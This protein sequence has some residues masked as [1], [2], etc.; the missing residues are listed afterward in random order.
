MA[1]LRLY[2][3]E[4]TP[5]HE[6]TSALGDPAVPEINRHPRQP[7]LLLGWETSGAARP[8]KIMGFEKPVTIP[9]KPKPRRRVVYRGDGHLLCV[10]PTGAGKGRGLIIPNLLHYPGPV[11]VS[12]PKGENFLV[13][14]LCRREMGH[15]VVALDP[16]RVAT[17]K[18]DWLNPFDVLKLPSSLPDADVE[19]LAELITGGELTCA[20]DPFWDLTGGGLLIGLLGLVALDDDPD[21]RNLAT[22]LDL[23]YDGDCDYKIA[24]ELDNKR[25]P[26][27]MIYNELAG[28]LSHESD[29]CRPSVRSTAQAKVKALGCEAVREAMSG[30][31]F[32]LNA[33]VR[34][35]PIDIFVILPPD[36][37]HSHRAVLRLWLGVIMTA[38]VRRT[39]IPARRT[40]VLLDE[41]AQLGPLNILRQAITLMR[42][43]GVQ[44]WTFWQDLSQLKLL[45]PQDWTTIVNNAAVI[46]AF[47]VSNGLMAAE[48][49]A[50][51]GCKPEELQ[52]LSPHRQFAMQ[53]RRGAQAIGRLD[54]L[55]DSFFRGRFLNNPRHA[56]HALGF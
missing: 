47:G 13:T 4:R 37:L 26:Q 17:D 18:G 2:H 38:L 24:V 7:G 41:A 1:A 51:L 53:P 8:P 28:Y 12:D 49:A 33:L 32:D 46:Q 11:I 54:Y 15:R 45:Y 55:R 31:T 29:R 43:Y 44:T 40:L 9:K 25:F 56:D 22:V 19:L 27:R 42:G 14:A 48:C 16:F 36:K 10:A 23:L 5:I 52:R 39:R 6:L 20:K 50:V 34:G 3:G 21:R 35:E 30:S